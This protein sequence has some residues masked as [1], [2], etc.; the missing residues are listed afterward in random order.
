[1]KTLKA[2]VDWR[3][4][5][6]NKPEFQLLMDKIPDFK[7][8]VHEEIAPEVYYTETDGYVSFFVNPDNGGALGGYVKDGKYLGGA[9]SSRA[10]YL[11]T[12]PGIKVADVSLTDDPE[13]YDRG[14]TFMAKHITLELLKEAAKLA[15][16]SL[17]KC[18]DRHGE[19]TFQPA[20]TSGVKNKDSYTIEEIEE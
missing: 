1:M 16:V 6:A 8:L 10:G 11:N 14:W 20:G 3:E 7:T 13:N 4:K 2:K 19:I 12:L 5:Y 15:N 9:W 18:T 17:A